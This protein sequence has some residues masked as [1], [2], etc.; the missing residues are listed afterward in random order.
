M[1]CPVPSFPPPCP[2]TVSSPMSLHLGPRSECAA[3]DCECITFISEDS[4]G[5]PSYTVRVFSPWIILVV[6]TRT[7]DFPRADIVCAACGHSWIAH[8]QDPDGVV[9]TN[10]RFM[11]GGAGNG[12][13]G[14]FHSVCA[15]QQ[16]AF[17]PVNSSQTEAS[18]NIQSRCLC[19]RPWAAHGRPP[20]A[21]K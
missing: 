3:R 12:L 15:A 8:G 21:V 9:P 13:C 6:L 4:D 1:L 2:C 17:P 14:A 18:W 7:K 16:F 10:Q 11:K 20:Q 19:G 5:S